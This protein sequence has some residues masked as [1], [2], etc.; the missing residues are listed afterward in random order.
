MAADDAAVTVVL[1]ASI[2][3]YEAALKSAVRATERA[4]TASEK[5]LSG[6]G[7]RGGASNV[8]QANFQK[9]AGAIAND[10]K[11]LQFQ[12]N[13]IFSG[14][15]SGQGIRA[16]QQQLG[17][18]AQQLSG[19]GLAAGARTMG[20]ALV[21]MVNPIN[22][23]VVA[24]GILASVAASYF[25]DSEEDAEKV[26]KKLQEQAKALEDL[27]KK[28]G[29]LLPE[30]ERKAKLDRQE[31]DQ[32]EADLARKKALAA[33][34]EQTSKVVDKTSD[35]ILVLV[36]A[37]Q[38][39]G[40]APK[41]IA[42]LVTDFQAFS[43]AVDNH[44]ATSKDAQKVIATLD[45]VIATQSGLVADLAKAI[46]EKLVASLNELDR[47]AKS[48]AKAGLGIT[49]IDITDALEKLI[50][51]DPT[52][53]LA[54]IDMLRRQLPDALGAAG[55][56]LSSFGSFIGKTWNDVGVSIKNAADLIKKEEGFTPTAKW[57]VNAFRVGFGSDT[58]VDAMGKVQKVTK[59][60][61]VTVDQATT[62]LNRR[63]GEFQTA[64]VSQIGPDF[65]RS[66]DQ[67]QQAALTSIAYN[68]GQLP[69]SIVKAIKEGDRG[70]V[71][72]AIAGLSA[73]PERRQ[74]EA[75]LF[76][77]G[78]GEGAQ[79][80]L[81]ALETQRDAVK[82][83]AEWNVETGRLIELQKQVAAINGQ[84]WLSEAERAAQVEA[85]QTAEEKL[86]ELRKAG[87]EVTAEQERQIRS[88]ADAQAHATVKS[89]EA[90][91][92]QKQV[93]ADQKKAAEEQKQINQQFAQVIGSGLSSLVQD[94]VAGKDAGDAFASAIQR[95]TSQL[96]DMMVQMLIIKPLMNAIGGA[97][98][99]G[100]LG[101]PVAP[102]GGLYHGG[103]TVGLSGRHDGR[104]FSPA[105]WAGAP[106]YAA[107]GIA[108][109]SPGEIPAILHR[110]E[111]VVPNARRLAGSGAG[112]GV[113]NTYS[114]DNAKI[115]IDMSGSGYVAANSD[116][117]KQFGQNVQKIIQ[118]EMVAQSMPG[119]LLRKLPR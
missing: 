67:A 31:A 2:K 28:Y 17:Q 89:Q 4:A 91:E 38:E 19:Q 77:Q 51:V 62:D 27:A 83:L 119:G 49:I 5:A 106:R 1:R 15:A 46:K 75:T 79:G 107:G 54:I 11:I 34:Y 81:K 102:G 103:G 65:W 40:S 35:D 100:I 98:G 87:V 25:G 37:M 86:T 47:A 92:R 20:A 55:G 41:G 108:G 110:G 68:Y 43:A 59:D 76:V 74:R 63:I 93:N 52:G 45:Q 99:G 71:G 88:L 6:I 61:V 21:G 114:M 26:T 113:Q 12:L 69:A 101:F 7:S 39:L 9:S 30:L 115:S 8:I 64:I 42:D 3:D 60:T 13:D 23:A 96:I 58:F 73:N 84:V 18:I 24:F 50:G 80:P 82:S 117:A 109:L 118:A 104:S 14:M 94:L 66:F 95:I 70:K 85:L 57:D 53:L 29:V 56:A 44:T 16:V 111:I 48:V 112:R 90:A 72:L 36:G 105:L 78:G 32:S 10:A 33:A 116:A 97:T 22:L